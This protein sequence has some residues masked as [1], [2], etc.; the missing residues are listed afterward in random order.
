[1]QSSA[2]KT[3]GA[4][5]VDAGRAHGMDIPAAD[6]ALNGGAGGAVDPRE[7]VLESALKKI[8]RRVLPLC[9]AVS[10]MNHLDRS[11]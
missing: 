3:N 11:K 8:G 1:M 9:I 5:F 7:A 2:V 10:L 6:A 4:E